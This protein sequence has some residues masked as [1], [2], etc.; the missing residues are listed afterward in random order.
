MKWAL[1]WAVM[2]I[3]PQ[4]PIGGNVPET[5]KFDSEK[6]CEAFGK[7]MSPRMQDWIRG[8]MKAEWEHPVRVDYKC[9]PDGRDA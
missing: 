3:G 2:T 7:D 5:T 6:A 9:Q 8:A 4:G 1:V